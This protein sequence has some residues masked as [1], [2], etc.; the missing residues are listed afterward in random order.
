VLACAIAF[1][2]RPLDVRAVRQH[3]DVLLL[4]GRLYIKGSSSGAEID[5]PFVMSSRRAH[6]RWCD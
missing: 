2:G 4:M 5:L 3:L 6:R 1:A